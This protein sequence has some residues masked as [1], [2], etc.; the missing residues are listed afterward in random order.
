MNDMKK[1]KFTVEFTPEGAAG[2][3]LQQFFPN[4]SQEDQI[5][6]AELLK[7]YWH[8]GYDAAKKGEPRA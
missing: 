3:F 1:I 4:A 5:A 7:A 2:L 6:L 8:G